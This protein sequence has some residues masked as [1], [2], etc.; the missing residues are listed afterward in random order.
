M[1]LLQL[2]KLGIL[3]SLLFSSTIF[4]KDIYSVGFAQDTMGND[5]RIAQVREV[6]NSFKNKEKVRFFYTNGKSNTAMQIMNIE[7]MINAKVDLIISSPRDAK[8]MT[9]V[10]EKAYNKGIPVVL[11]SRTIQSDKYTTFIHP[12][13]TL[14][15]KQAARFIAK[16]LDGKGNVLVLQHTPTST[17]GIRRTKGF[18]EEIKKFPN[19]KIVATKVANSQ[20]SEAII[21]TEEAIKEGLKFDAI[22]AQSDSMAIGAIMALKANGIDPKK[23]V[24][25]GIDYISQ[26]AD[27][28]KK[29]ELDA[30]YV[31][32]TGGKQGVEVAMKI[33]SGKK[34][35]KEIIIESAQITIDNVND[36]KP[37]F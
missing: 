29:G 34:V 18:N 20:R 37:I 22:Y 11:L 26:A 24:I 30:S 4:A 10:I 31:Y 3:A 1:K 12:K 25:T 5:W 17:P 13:N 6:E 19:I 27:L 35:P 32:P 23:I 14:I 7:D 33:L 21:K 15:A 28:I 8:V 2:T 36:I 16:K 9:P